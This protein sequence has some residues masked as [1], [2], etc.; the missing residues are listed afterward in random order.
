M[1]RDR[2]WLF[3]AVLAR[4]LATGMIGVLLGVYLAA[5]DLP[6]TTVGLIIGLG[7]AGAALATTVVTFLADRIGHRRCLLAVTAF[8]VGGAIAMTIT[9]SP[10]ALGV[11]AFIGMV[12]GM[13]RDRGAALVIEQAAL[14]ATGTDAERTMTFAK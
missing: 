9:T 5:L 6:A 2:R 7:L 8:T 13:G 10:W 1:S 11:A 4:S 3:L 12:N 14:P